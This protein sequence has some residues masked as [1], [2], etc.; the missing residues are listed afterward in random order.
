MSAPLACPNGHPQHDPALAAC[1]V[2]GAA[3]QALP[4]DT[5]TLPPPAAAT[6]GGAFTRKLPTGIAPAEAAASPTIAVPG[7]EILGELGRGGMGVVYKARQLGLNRVV[8]LKMIL[9][10]SHAAPEDLARFRTEAEAVARL[11]HPN[12]VAVYE[13]GEHHGLPF[14]ALEYCSG[15][16]LDRKLHAR[17]PTPSPEAGGLLDVLAR[18]LQAAQQRGLVR[19][20]VKAAD[21][22]RAEAA[23]PLPAAEAAALV[24]VLARAMHYAHQKGVLHRDLKPA[25]VLL[26][27][28]GTPKITDFGLARKVDD[29]HQTASG[30][31]LGTPSYMAPEQA[32][33]KSKDIGPVSDVWALGAVLYEC[34]TARPPFRAATSLDTILQVLA[35]EPPPLRQVRPELPRDLETICHKC[36]QKE[37]GRRYGTAL[38]LAED[39]RH[40]RTGEP[41]AARAIGTWGRLGRWCRRNP[42]SA[43]LAAAL[44]LALVLGTLIATLVAVQAGASAEEADRRA[45]SASGEA[46]F[47]HEAEWQARQREDMMRREAREAHRRAYDAH[48]QLAQVAWE[49]RQTDRLRELLERTTP[50]PGRDDLRGFEWYYWKNRPG[51]APLTLRGHN[52]AVRGMAF[53]PDG[54]RLA[55]A[56]ADRLMKVWDLS[57][58]NEIGSLRVPTTALHAVAFSP[59]GTCL[60]SAALDQTIELRNTANGASRATLRGHTGEIFALC[61]SPDS[62][63]IASGSWDRT[64]RVWDATT[65]QLLLTLAGHTQTVRSVALSP[66]ANLLASGCEDGAVKVWEVATSQVWHAFAGGAG[67]I[68]GL[69]FSPNARRL[70]AACGDGVIRVWDTTTGQEGLTLRGH[71]GPATGVCFGPGGSRL[72][73]AGKDGTVRVWNTASGEELLMLKGPPEGFGGV[74]FSPGGKHLAARGLDG[75]LTVWD[76]TPAP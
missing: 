41:I 13:V 29:A 48:M 12:I 56:G 14:L 31:I 53:N 33:G 39:L 70:A 21:V 36:L 17:S 20:D 57:T 37:P 66:T 4:A 51:R 32:A 67:I 1:P 73:S 63:R 43:G 11:Q 46:R 50:G 15:G 62:S 28:D 3:L 22:L 59:D 75:T 23:T 18:A 76:A 74:A 38:A 2:C 72:A 65:G 30:A 26:A 52:G 60:A 16:G 55:S 54:K 8:A 34:L 5:A 10:G 47:A 69:A 44:L 40:F 61:F 7:Y 45:A 71:T 9:A 25:N 27:E 6:P 24:E 35:D 64:V 42:A 58:A 49:R 68:H 19:S